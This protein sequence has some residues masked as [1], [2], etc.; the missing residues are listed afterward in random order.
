MEKNKMG[1]NAASDIDITFYAAEC[2]EF[3]RYGEYREGL[4]T[5]E[6]A[7]KY[8]DEIPADRLNAVKGIGIHVHD[9]KENGFIQEYPLL[10]GKTVDLDMLRDSHGISRY[11]QILEIAKTLAKQREDIT[12]EDS[13]G[14]LKET[15]ITI[16][17]SELA[18]RVNDLQRKIDPDFYSQFYP[19]ADK[20]EKKVMMKLLTEDGR[21][22]YLS[23]LKAGHMV[24]QNE[25]RAEAE[26]ISRL[27]E[28]AQIQW[29]EIMPP[30]VFIC[31]SETYELED[32]DVIPLEEA[33]PIFERLDRT[34]VKE[35]KENNTGGYDKTK[36]V[37]YYQMNGEPSTYEGRQ[38][39]FFF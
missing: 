34:R 25:V 5:L 21:N 29:P 14:I 35:N 7:L 8:Y 31:W 30:F 37:I 39:F 12:V 28:H 22:E 15:E 23:W 6:E 10:M 33:D 20:Q 3:V 27:L 24:L 9:P 26:D 17:A 19:D 38:D 18:K 4:G 16:G 32:G 13:H 36:F 11:P 1:E 2:M